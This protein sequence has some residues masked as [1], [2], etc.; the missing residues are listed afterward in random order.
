MSLILNLNLLWTILQQHVKER[1]IDLV[2]IIFFGVLEADIIN[3]F[4]INLVRV[5]YIN[6][7]NCLSFE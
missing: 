3:N 2:R 7:S 4:P 5:I 1:P 6:V